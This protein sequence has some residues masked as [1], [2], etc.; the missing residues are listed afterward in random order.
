MPALVFLA[1]FAVPVAILWVSYSLGAFLYQ[2]DTYF[3]I[4][5]THRSQIL[6]WNALALRVDAEVAAELD[7]LL[8]AELEED[9]HS[10]RAGIAA[11]T[12]SIEQAASLAWAHLYLVMVG[13][14]AL[15]VA[16]HPS[17]GS[18]AAGIIVAGLGSM[19]LTARLVWLT[20]YTTAQY[21]QI[22]KAL[23]TFQKP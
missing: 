21:I 4:L 9:R 18:T 13:F 1:S 20:H 19:A 16:L 22:Q 17:L 12:I 6:A 15:L 5:R 11:M 23:A 8:R 3:E 10:L 14:T 7:P 2:V